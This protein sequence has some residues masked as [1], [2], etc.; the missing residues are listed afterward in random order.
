[1]AKQK[2]GGFS[3]GGQVG[4]FEGYL[5]A[6]PSSRAN[7]KSLSTAIHADMQLKREVAESVKREQMID[8][9][10]Q[11][12]PAQIQTVQEVENFDNA[13]VNQTKVEETA[14]TADKSN[15][16]WEMISQAAPLISWDKLT[17]LKGWY[18]SHFNNPALTFADAVKNSKFKNIDE[19]YADGKGGFFKTVGSTTQVSNAQEYADYQKEQSKL[20]T[21]RDKAVKAGS[22]DAGNT[23]APMLRGVWN[24]VK[25]TTL[26]VL[27]MADN[28]IANTYDTPGTIFSQN[29]LKQQAHD[30]QS[31]FN[32]TDLKLHELTGIGDSKVKEDLRTGADYHAKK[33]KEFAKAHAAESAGQTRQSVIED[34]RKA[35]NEMLMG[36]GLQKDARG[37]VVNFIDSTWKSLAESGRAE[38]K[39]IEQDMSAIS[40]YDNSLSIISSAVNKKVGATE[41]AFNDTGVV[42]KDK[43]QVN[44]KSVPRD[45][46]P[47]GRNSFLDIE[48][49]AY[50]EQGN[51]RTDEKGDPIYEAKYSGSDLLTKPRWSALADPDYLLNNVVSE[52]LEEIPEAALAYFTGTA[53]KVGTGL[54]NKMSQKAIKRNLLSQGFGT[55]VIA[56]AETAK[57]TSLIA[58]D[59]QETVVNDLIDK[60]MKAP[61]IDDLAE[62]MLSRNPNMSADIAFMQAE[63]RLKRMRADWAEEHVD[64]A[65]E[66]AMRGSM[67]YDAAARLNSISYLQNLSGARLFAGKTS[68]M[69]QLVKNPLSFRG[70][71]KG[72]K[73]VVKESA[74]EAVLEEAILNTVS[75]RA[76]IAIG[77][78]EQYN[79]VKDIFEWDSEQADSAIAGFFSGGAMATYGQGMS[80]SAKRK[81]YKDQK[82]TLAAM[83]LET[84]K[85]KKDFVETLRLGMNNSAMKLGQ[86]KV[87]AHLAAKEFI[88]ADEAMSETYNAQMIAH[89]KRGTLG[90]YIRTLDKLNIPG[91]PSDIDPVVLE[92]AKEHAEKIGAKFDEIANIPGVDVDAAMVNYANRMTLVNTYKNLTRLRGS[93]TSAILAGKSTPNFEKIALDDNAESKIDALEVE[94]DIVAALRSIE[95][96]IEESKKIYKKIIHH[97]KI[98]PTSY[99]E[100]KAFKDV[101][102]T[103]TSTEEL[104][105][106]FL[107][108]LDQVNS[109]PALQAQVQ[110][111]SAQLQENAN[112]AASVEASANSTAEATPAPK[113]PG[114][115]PTSVTAAAT[116]VAIQE[117]KNTPLVDT[118]EDDDLI[119]ESL[120]FGEAATN[121][122]LAE[123]EV[124]ETVEEAVEGVTEEAPAEVSYDFQTEQEGQS[125]ID[126]LER[127]IQDKGGMLANPQLSPEEISVIEGQIKTAEVEL[128]KAKKGLEALIKN[129]AQQ[130]VKQ[131]KKVEEVKPPVVQ[132]KSTK[133]EFPIGS[134]GL[135]KGGLVKAGHIDERT[136]LG[137]KLLLAREGLDKN[138]DPYEVFFGSHGTVLPGGRMILEGAASD[139][140]PVYIP[141]KG[142]FER[143]HE[144]TPEA[145][146]LP[147]KSARRKISTKD[148]PNIVSAVRNAILAEQA[149]L[150]SKLGT[151][152]SFWD[153]LTHSV[154]QHGREYV[155]E[156]FS[157]LEYGWQLT[158]RPV[159]FTGTTVDLH[160]AFFDSKNSM[161][162]LIG[163]VLTYEDEM[164]EHGPAP[165]I[166]EDINKQNIQVSH[167]STKVTEVTENVAE[168]TKTE[169]LPIDEET[170]AE[171]YDT[172][173]I[174]ED[175]TPIET[176]TLDITQVHERQVATPGVMM[177][178]LGGQ[179]IVDEDGVTTDVD[180]NIPEEQY[181][182]EGNDVWWDFNLSGEGSEVQ[183]IPVPYE[184]AALLQVANYALDE[185]T[186]RVVKQEAVTFGSLF[187]PD[188]VGS[189]EYIARVPMRVHTADGR[190]I[191]W[192]HDLSWVNNRNMANTGDQD[193]LI[194]ASRQALL[195]TRKKA[196]NSPGGI[197]GHIAKRRMG[198]FLKVSAVQNDTRITPE[199]RY[200]PISVMSPNSI[201]AVAKESEVII[202]DGVPFKGELINSK[203]FKA[204]QTLELRHVNTKADGTKQYLA[205]PTKGNNPAVGE[206]MPEKVFQTLKRTLSAVLYLKTGL[207][208]EPTP[209]NFGIGSAEHVVHS[210][211]KE[212]GMDKTSALQIVSTINSEMGM[213]ILNPT[214]QKGKGGL[215]DFL[216]SFVQVE[217]NIE[218]YLKNV[219]NT[220]SVQKEGGVP[221]YDSPTG[222]SHLY[223]SNEGKLTVYHKQSQVA[224]TKEEITKGN[225]FIFGKPAMGN[226]RFTIEKILMESTGKISP[227]RRL[228]VRG[229]INSVGTNKGMVSVDE[230]N[231][232]VPYGEDDPNAPEGVSGYDLFLKENRQT[233][234]YAR[235]VVD[236]KTGEVKYFTDIQP[237]IELEFGSEP[238]G[239]S[240]EEKAMVDPVVAQ[241]TEAE[242]TG[243]LPVPPST[244]SEEAQPE[245]VKQVYKSRAEEQA[246]LPAEFLEAFSKISFKGLEKDLKL[247]MKSSRRKLTDIMQKSLEAIGIPGIP[248]L[249]R[250][251]YKLALKSLQGFVMDNL[252]KKPELT[253]R[254]IL[255]SVQES[256]KDSVEPELAKVNALLEQLDK[257]GGVTSFPE[258]GRALTIKQQKLQA[259]LDHQAELLYKKVGEPGEL[260]KSINSQLTLKDSEVEDAIVDH[261]YDQDATT[262]KVKSTFSTDLKVFFSGVKVYDAEGNVQTN[263]LGI[264]EYVSADKVIAKVRNIM[265]NIPSSYEDLLQELKKNSNDPVI[266]SVLVKL[267]GDLPEHVKNQL[268]Y[269]LIQNKL[270][271]RSVVYQLRDSGKFAMQLFNPNKT[272]AS[273]RQLQEWKALWKMSPAFSEDGEQFSEPYITEM[274]QKVNTLFADLAMEPALNKRGGVTPVEYFARFKEIFDMM[275]MSVDNTTLVSYITNQKTNIRNNRSFLGNLQTALNTIQLQITSG[276]A[277]SA[278]AAEFDL[279][280][281]LSGNIKQ[282]SGTK[283]DLEGNPLAKSFRAGGKSYQGTVQ[284]MMAYKMVDELK[285]VDADGNRS[286]NFEALK[287]IPFSKGSFL[288]KLLELSSEFNNVFNLEFMGPEALSERSTDN[289][290]GKIQSLG[291]P[292]RIVTELGLFMNTSS[293]LK[294]TADSI[295]NQVANGIAIR[296]G[297]MFNAA[298]SDKSNSIH[299]VTALL[300]LKTTD[301]S[302]QVTD[303]EEEFMRISPEVL[304]FVTDQVYGSEL[305]RIFAVRA[306][307]LSRVAGYGTAGKYFVT[308][309]AYNTMT[310]VVAGK[311][312]SMEQ[313]LDDPS[314]GE[315]LIREAFM[316]VATDTTYK[317]LQHEYYLKVGTGG[318]WWKAGLVRET[319]FTNSMGEVESK[320]VFMA[321]S[322]YL[323]KWGADATAIEAMKYTAM[324]FVVNNYLH[325]HQMAQ[326]VYGDPAYFSPG[327]GKKTTNK[328]GSINFL[329]LAKKTGESMT[330]RM[331]ML[332][333]PGS[334]LANSKGEKYLQIM[335]NDRKSMGNIIPS[336][337][338]QMYGEYPSHIAEKYN[339]IREAEKQ[340]GETLR[341]EDTQ[342]REAKVKAL[343]D[344]ISENTDYIASVYPALEDYMKI[345]GTDAQEYTTW[346]EHFDIVFRQGRLSSKDKA[347]LESAYAK[348]KQ[349]GEAELTGDEL[350]AIVTNPLKPV[351]TGRE[352]DYLQNPDGTYDKSQPI[353][354]R[355]VY[356]KSSS[357]PLL[358][359]LTKGLELDAVRQKMEKLA[360]MDLQGSHLKSGGKS[361]RGVRLSYQTANKVGAQVSSLTIDDLYYRTFDEL[362]QMDPE[363]GAFSGPLGNAVVELSRENFRIQ[364]DVPDKM[365]KHIAEKIDDV[366]I[367][368][369]QIW[370]ILMGNG[371]NGIAEAVFPDTFSPRVRRYLNGINKV[372]GAEGELTGP[373]LDALKTEIERTYGQNQLSM[374]YDEL[375]LTK[376]GQIRD[377]NYTMQAVKKVIVS[378]LESKDYP[379]YIVDGLDLVDMPEGDLEFQIPL[380]M[381]PNTNK[382]ESL[383][384]SIISNRLI[385]YKLPGYQHVSASAEGF[386]KPQIGAVEDLDYNVR[387][388]IVYTDPNFS[389]ELASTRYSD[390][391]LKFSQVFIKSHF[392]G[393]VDIKNEEGEVVG[394]EYRLID[395]SKEPYSKYDEVT[396]R[397]ILDPEM[398]PQKLREMFSFRIPTSALQSGAMLEVVGFLPPES[399]DT[400]VVPKEHTTQLGEDFDVDKR[401]LYKHHYYVDNTGAIKLYELPKGVRFNEDY[402]S[403]DHKLYQDTK[404]S[405]QN[406]YDLVRDKQKYIK[407]QEAMGKLVSANYELK[408]LRE[409]LSK[410]EELEGSLEEEQRELLK[411]NEDALLAILAVYPQDTEQSI[412]EYV[413]AELDNM[414]LAVSMLD[415]SEV[416]NFNKFRAMKA[417]QKHVQKA[418]ENAMIDCYT[419]VYTSKSK[420]V[421][422]KIM[423]VLSF[424]FAEKSVKYI[425][426]RRTSGNDAHFNVYSDEYQADQMAL[427]ASGKTGISVWSNAVVAHSQYERLFKGKKVKLKRKYAFGDLP[428]DGTLGNTKTLDGGRDIAD[429]LSE[430]QNSATDNVKAQVMGKRNENA[431]TLN[432]MVL[433]FKLG[434]DKSKSKIEA[435]DD[436]ISVPSMF[437]S[438]PVMWDYVELMTN[439]RGVTSEF[440]PTPDINTI[441]ELANKYGFSHLINKDA[442]AKKDFENILYLGNDPNLDYEAAF[443]DLTKKHLTAENLYKNLDPATA[444]RNPEV[445]ALV[446]AQ[447]LR[448]DADAK[449]LTKIESVYNLNTSGLD[450]SY[451]NV[452]DKLDVM[453][454]MFN[455]PHFENMGN[456]IGDFI[457]SVV[458][459]KGYTSIGNGLQVRP[460]T[461]EGIVA[462]NALKAGDDIMQKLYPYRH[463]TIVA[464]TEKVLD[465]Y[466]GFKTELSKDAATEVRYAM[467][468][469]L[470]EY[471]FN[472][473]NSGLFD[474][475]IE[476]ERERLFGEGAKSVIGMIKTLKASGHSLMIDNPLLR[477]IEFVSDLGKGGFAIAVSGDREDPDDKRDKYHA[478]IELLHDNTSTIIT[479]VDG[480]KITPQMLALDLA[481]YSYMSRDRKGFTGLRQFV[482]IEALN[483]LGFTDFL[484]G[485]NNRLDQLDV[486]SFVRQFIQHNPEYA[487]KFSS[488]SHGVKAFAAARSADNATAVQKLFDK[489]LQ[490]SAKNPDRKY[491]KLSDAFTLMDLFELKDNSVTPQ[492]M[493]HKDS[494]SGRIN[495]FEGRPTTNGRVIYKRISEV[496]SNIKNMYNVG[497]SSVHTTRIS[498]R[499]NT[500]NDDLTKVLKRSAPKKQ[501]S[502]SGVATLFTELPTD[503]D[504]LAGVV[505]TLIKT[506]GLLE[507]ALNFTDQ[508]KN[509]IARLEAFS[510]DLGVKVLVATDY[511]KLTGE[512]SSAIGNYDPMTNTIIL[513]KDFA[514][515][516]P[517]RKGETLS[518]V[519]Y[520]TYVEELM[521]SINHAYLNKFIVSEDYTTG[522]VTLTAD[523]PKEV[524]ELARMYEEVVASGS[525]DYGAV[526]GFDEFVANAMASPE[527]R[528]DIGNRFQVLSQRL[529]QLIMDIFNLATNNT[530]PQ[531]VIVALAE[532]LE[533]G[534]GR[535]T[536]ELNPIDA[537]DLVD[538][539]GIQ[540]AMDQEVVDLMAGK[541]EIHKAMRLLDSLDPNDFKLGDSPYWTEQEKTDKAN[542]GKNY[543][544]PQG[545][546]DEGLDQLDAIREG[547]K[548]GFTRV[549]SGTTAA[550][551]LPKELVKVEIATQFIGQGKADSSTDRYS[552]EWAKEG[553]ANTGNYKSSDVVMLA[554]NG[555]RGGAFRPIINGVL[556]GNYK[557][558]DQAIAAGASFVADTE[559][560]LN[561]SSKYNTGEV[562]LAE[563]LK[564]KGYTYSTV[565]NAGLW[566]RTQGGIKPL[567]NRLPEIKNCK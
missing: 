367:M 107:E 189:P 238:V 327:I 551:Y 196:F 247:P 298:L 344:I 177:A 388:R 371:V 259:I 478:F 81:H 39:G 125:V 54:I 413:Q 349:N 482:P 20:N 325:Q 508:Q 462:V 361:L 347:L 239:L 317:V 506:H 127:D 290:S 16:T 144:G 213:D 122:P 370:K 556:Q 376:D 437:T 75:E 330:K 398:L 61:S 114:N 138:G 368:G 498:L 261:F 427:G 225:D 516:V 103:V 288:L 234:V 323:E 335:V 369:S 435:V 164:L 385:R 249:D 450:Q 173:E 476:L 116:A 28:S 151:R 480:E 282:V 455:N 48:T 490:I 535:R 135:M 154:E 334:V 303:K 167:N 199:Q 408:N 525:K 486:T 4:G 479:T 543:K 71:A 507:S 392:R 277:Y 275:G 88:K 445:Q 235:R 130:E 132:N 197:K 180:V 439:S 129:S 137:K 179:Y 336:L 436:H 501:E 390:G 219:N 11:P 456:V 463:P 203:T 124:K 221:K 404:E 99:N 229:D 142:L 12:T 359:Q 231:E 537:V 293:L 422:D 117:M 65:Q 324:D 43:V 355:T 198:G 560:H 565:N 407:A 45:R 491:S 511:D 464:I 292:D 504:T 264:P 169:A 133:Q 191:N 14:K 351:H 111:K 55:S 136:P 497:G 285:E 332:I 546:A 545:G 553:L 217:T 386:Q 550:K 328:D 266:K 443:Y 25:S 300:D 182:E 97:N 530:A 240:Q 465:I 181:L 256:L 517:L 175:T 112:I 230:Y 294:N 96:Q 156:N 15:R 531:E 421:Q 522:K 429:T 188:D 76:G 170:E 532:Y 83:Q 519:F 310:A 226:A 251:Q 382:F 274:L 23:I 469:S 460:T 529:K 87:Q 449:R 237:V 363:T 208:T 60:K 381:S 272:E 31:W 523:A 566:I 141:M 258:V 53:S 2:Y 21:L 273:I 80:V 348:L 468:E 311:S 134:F 210:Y 362:F 289:K 350:M 19:V 512:S 227:L 558:I 44:G 564:N 500:I 510:A 502:A 185:T 252:S 186:G 322:Q 215:G 424:A 451:F 374:L 384:Q 262:K 105:N 559:A 245:E 13:V 542:L 92:Q 176:N 10:Y 40:D 495:L 101:L 178:G 193:Q 265:V 454:S 387:S 38:A 69:D 393:M 205:L 72:V 394:Q 209:G 271:M 494:R 146:K 524:V 190:Q 339:A 425:Q 432:A 6:N 233:D 442:L 505:T 109:S 419:S 331:A 84:P 403:I 78:G 126:N 160:D 152:A 66:I 338:N 8:P 364:M 118:E 77:K 513:P 430:N 267:E 396:G 139:G 306:N 204:G 457:D 183:L 315:D 79:M 555:N 474:G 453:Q 91:A 254:D 123:P 276:V 483:I 307:P 441:E 201:M 299:Y 42:S 414:E 206:L 448:L 312:M 128:T 211:F 131:T 98:D 90:E 410:Y 313:A 316:A 67:A 496:E 485:E 291:K 24:S 32:A 161:E 526:S 540:E 236:K 503:V 563:Y 57:E 187:G 492:F 82:N 115:T 95:G 536:A 395:L 250:V 36:V 417:T 216:S 46:D 411:E 295:K 484:R 567:H 49:I 377:M 420:K 246:N 166:Q 280:E 3:P 35:I 269:N 7:I 467:M 162:S 309:P 356:I 158:G 120:L 243:E 119:D 147:M 354:M 527:F 341:I 163:S 489:N 318:S 426:E 475:S 446:L 509:L 168:D 5:N 218:Q 499:K 406:V 22:D 29:W 297:R 366:I 326:L 212:I 62:Q 487:G 104:T 172:A 434:F 224:K 50:D 358:P 389:G 365:S 93:F 255:M 481:V 155:W 515:R 148:N 561:K 544:Q 357:F 9:K 301:L 534:A 405:I 547:V 184:E 228:G 56:A 223:L 452:M 415:E 207:D 100:R 220:N 518:D 194:A 345:E 214:N 409:E 373:G 459:V 41:S 143:D 470:R 26:G 279:Y 58:L 466:K 320:Q 102:D 399:G 70:L 108:K 260:A 68:I 284:T 145:I 174:E 263:F 85:I 59:A 17:N 375:G 257:L 528:K 401:S 241:V 64:E 340:M 379:E 232:A 471:F 18:N 106:L 248:G 140:T 63:K 549:T 554:A 278:K 438:Q 74:K 397:Y 444:G 461:T 557:L 433:M 89:A 308:T 281:K 113:K 1:M 153:Y 333:A 473:P 34:R 37:S 548:Q 431:Y 428:S 304:S 165:E 195:E 521:H 458:P 352:I 244:E 51:I 253:R 372:I 477:D 562:A 150:D 86:E 541:S 242:E 488:V 353:G 283:L 30:L 222:V 552:K 416:N 520:E 343:Q 192:I 380:W 287:K 314:I 402:S 539:Y 533:Y 159:G 270:E 149:E 514:T 202:S 286:E 472:D 447:F 346:Q 329:Q 157:W 33:G 337:I 73:E 360:T 440:N 110:Q 412:M 493:V 378:E 200:S 418:L 400:I 538:V 423:K 268:L 391:K 383:L 296:V 94:E 47:N 321:D 27:N 171:E 302:L 319:T 121:N 52:M 342:E 305:E